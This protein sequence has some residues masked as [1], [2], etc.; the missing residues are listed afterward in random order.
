MSRGGGRPVAARPRDARQPL[1]DVFLAGS[2]QLEH[3]V[4]VVPGRDLIADL[5]RIEPF[6]GDRDRLVYQFLG[7]AC[8]RAWYLMR[9]DGADSGFTARPACALTV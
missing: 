8:Q 4:F 9:I 5:Q 6:E 3:D 1:V 2:L 7:G